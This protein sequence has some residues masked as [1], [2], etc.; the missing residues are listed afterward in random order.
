MNASERA[1]VLRVQL[2]KEQEQTGNASS[3]KKVDVHGL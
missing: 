3:S 1:A 2:S